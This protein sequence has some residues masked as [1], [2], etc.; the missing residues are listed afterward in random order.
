MV[1]ANCWWQDDYVSFYKE[2]LPQKVKI[3]VWSYEW[4]EREFHKWAIWNW[5]AALGSPRILYMPAGV[6]FE[7]PQ[8]STQQMIRN[9]GTD[10][11]ISTADALGI[12]SCIFFDGWD[13]G[14]ERDRLRDLALTQF[15]TSTYVSGQEQKLDLIKKLYDD[16]FGAR[17]EVLH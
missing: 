13:L 12:K 7:Y 8:D 16:Y 1:M 2:K 3:C 11:L 15:P 5:T 17:E 4:G 6:A 14:T 9:L 10:R